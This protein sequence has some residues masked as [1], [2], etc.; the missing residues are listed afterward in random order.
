MT[1]LTLSR[2]YFSHSFLESTNAFAPN[3]IEGCPLRS[4]AQSMADVTDSKQTHWQVASGST[5]TKPETAHHRWP[6]LALLA[7][8][9]GTSRSKLHHS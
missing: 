8:T 6:T 9:V 5:R 4:N 3:H 2:H 7:A 1:F